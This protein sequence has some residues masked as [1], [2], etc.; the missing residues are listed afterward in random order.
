MNHDKQ[1]AGR[2]ALITG[3]SRGIGAAIAMAY[4]KE[5][6]D[7]VIG[8]RTDSES[9][10]KVIQSIRSSGQKGLAVQADVSQVEDV[11][12]MVD[13]TI[14]EFGRLD[15][16]VNNAGTIGENNLVDMPIEEW[17][18]VIGVD[19]RGV[20]LCT[21]FVLPQMLQQKSG[22]I[23][24]IASELALKGRARFAHYAA[25]KGG[26][27]SFSRSMALELAPDILIN[28]IAPGP[29]ETDLILAE[30]EPEWIEKEKDIPLRRLGKPEEV[31][32]TA[33]LLASDGGNFYTGQVLSPNG[34]A[35]FF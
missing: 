11:K 26:V 30:M 31:A 21:K 8:Y 1:L 18:H 14:R 29:I 12:H 16:L 13:T 35:V 15:I 28:V 20:F 4:A 10:E 9:A 22:K 25:A 19:L 27:I 34:G 7:V 23:I 3:G 5:G 24:N 32:A 17:D 6:A 33:V 2:V